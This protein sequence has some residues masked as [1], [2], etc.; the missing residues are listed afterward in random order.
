MSADVVV[1]GSGSIGQRHARVL[2]SVGA[3]V[4]LWPVRDRGSAASDADP[5][6]GAR[7]L[8]DSTGP[9]ALAAADLVVVAT[10]TSRHVPDAILALDAGARRVLVEKPVAATAERPA[11]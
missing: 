3:Q 9:A 2:A 10:D 6:T 4:S 11:P 8:D 1:R 7:L 5:A